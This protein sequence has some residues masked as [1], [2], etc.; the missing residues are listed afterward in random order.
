VGLADNFFQLGGDS[1][2]AVRLVMQIRARLGS[3]LPL[4]AV[5]ESPALGDLAK[6]IAG[7]F[8]KSAAFSSLFPIRIAGSLPP[9]FCMHPIGGLCWSYINL[10][11]HT[12]AEQPIYGVQAPHFI[13]HDGLPTTIDEIISEAIK[14]IRSVNPDRPYRLLGW[15][16]GGILAHMTAT[17]LQAEG[18]IVERL[19]L[20]DSYPPFIIPH[21]QQLDALRPDGIWRD[22]ASGLDLSVPQDIR[23]GILNVHSIFRLA[24][25]QSHPIAALSL[26]QLE[27]FA[28]VMSNNS[29]FLGSLV[30][31]RFRGDITLVVAKNRSQ[32]FNH[33]AMSPKAWIPYCEGAIETVS[34][35]STHNK[36]LSAATL[37]QV[38]FLR[39]DELR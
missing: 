10:L 36:I 8:D 5:F 20:F 17:R 31:E 28:A 3:D 18:S 35:N 15:S 39:R 34:V 37:K 12:S 24:Q 9:L 27:R 13:D 22:L 30:L 7:G 33:E 19:V 21:L 29:R 14:E 4:H 26:Q 6:R 32:G 2:T 16:F 38:E 23:G 25:D 11:G 1:L